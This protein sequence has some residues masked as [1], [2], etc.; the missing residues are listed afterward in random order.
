MDRRSFLHAASAVALAGCAAP[1]GTSGPPA[2]APGYRVGDRWIYSARDG[3]RNP[4]FWDETHEV[5]AAGPD[6]IVIR[7]TQ[8]GPTVDNSRTERLVAPGIVTVGA[9]FDNETR[10]FATPLRR[11]EFPLTTGA[12]WNQSLANFNE[13]LGRE[14]P[15]QRSVFVGGWQSVSTPAGSFDAITLRV[16]MQLNL[17]DPFNLPTQCNYEIWWAP[18]A[19]AMVRETRSASYRQRGDAGP[20]AEIRSQNAVLELTSY[21]RAGA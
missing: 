19:G 5:E 12:R 16:F 18:A 3:F 14:D 13:T 2:Q 10:R 15:L 4:V 7:V 1:G 21:R 11:Y 6:G 20:M 8:K 9:V 17:N